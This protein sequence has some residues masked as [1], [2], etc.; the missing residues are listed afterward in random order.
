MS[1]LQVMI[2]ALAVL[3]TACIG[4]RTYTEQEQST[5]AQTKTIWVDILSDTRSF[6]L[7][8][9]SIIERVELDVKDKL[10]RAGF[11]VVPDQSAAD[12]VL[13]LAFDFSDRRHRDELAS[14]YESAYRHEAHSIHVGASLDHKTVGHLLWHGESVSPP[15]DLNLSHSTIIRDIDLDVLQALFK[16]TTPAKH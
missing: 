4:H 16:S 8:T 15:Y 6:P 1:T 3:Q 2:V 9:T 7:G 11:T 5:L 10:T 14:S 12:A 13:Q